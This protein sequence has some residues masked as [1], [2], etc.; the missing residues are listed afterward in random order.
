MEGA[1][2]GIVSPAQEVYVEM[3]GLPTSIEAAIVNLKEEF[4]KL[5]P[6]ISPNSYDSATVAQAWS[7]LDRLDALEAEVRAKLPQQ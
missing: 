6:S 4:E 1:Q 3:E 2:E 5:L 7:V